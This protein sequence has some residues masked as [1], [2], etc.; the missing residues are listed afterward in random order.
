MDLTGRRRRVWPVV[1]TPAKKSAAISGRSCR[2][3]SDC[4]VLESF[5]LSSRSAKLPRCGVDAF[6]WSSIL[7]TRPCM[8]GYVGMRCLMQGRH[9]WDHGTSACE[10]FGPW[11]GVGCN[12]Y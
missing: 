8:H 5:V 9:D 12:I 7:R 10:S 6:M 3:S 2:S 11:H 4:R 1:S